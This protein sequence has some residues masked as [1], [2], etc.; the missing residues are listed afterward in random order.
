MANITHSVMMKLTRATFGVAM[1]GA[2]LALTSCST[3]IAHQDGPP[4]FYVDE[5]KVP[6]ATP[7]PEPL[8][9]HGNMPSY[10][11]FGRRYY[12]LKSS[13]HYEQEGI[14]SWYGTQFHEHLTSSGEPY[15]MLGMTAAHKTLPLPTY[16]EVTNLKNQRKIIVKVN[17][18]GPFAPG[19]IIDLS[20]VAAKKLGMLGHGTTHV[21]VKAIDPTTF[22]ETI[23]LAAHAPISAAKALYLQVGAFHDRARAENLR[24]RLVALLGKPIHIAAGKLYRVQ[25]GPFK[26][27]AEANTFSS[28]LKSLGIQANKRFA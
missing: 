15:N 28:R 9:K 6:N 27:A 19:R 14:A 1:L 16:V 12:T 23:Q 18:R 10:T 11:V 22:G 24:S 26:T 7:K 13:K 20:Y 25:M 3:Q 8:A 5:K 4:K 21:R 17:D 2:A